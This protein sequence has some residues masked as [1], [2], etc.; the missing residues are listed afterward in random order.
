MNYFALPSSASLLAV[1]NTS[2]LTNKKS[3][4][5]V[6]MAP[7]IVG[8]SNTQPSVAPFTASGA[9]ILATYN[10]VALQRSGGNKNNPSARVGERAIDIAKQL[11]EQA[12]KLAEE[13]SK[14]KKTK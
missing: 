12:K 14:K 13:A 6:P 1:T 9:G 3:P 2:A 7:A 10:Q 4:A 11:A 5:S 8:S